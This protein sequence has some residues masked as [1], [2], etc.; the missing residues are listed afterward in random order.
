MLDFGSMLIMPGLLLFAFK[1]ADFMSS[2]VI[3]NKTKPDTFPTIH[4]SK[5]EYRTKNIFE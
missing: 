4:N 5:C 2:E 3:N 1:L